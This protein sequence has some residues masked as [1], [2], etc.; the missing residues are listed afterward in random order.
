MKNTKRPSKMRGQSWKFQWMRVCRAR[1]EH[2][3]IARHRK[4]KREVVNPTRFQKQ[5]MHVSWKRMSPRDSDWNP[6][7]QKSNEDHIA[8]KGQNSMSHYS[9]V[10]R[11]TP[12]PQA[13][14]ILDAKAAVEKEWKN[15]K[16]RNRHDS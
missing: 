12:I 5:S 16:R 1:K 6:L 11:F 14:K 13:M 15:N 8:D 7:F 4:L 10:H 9:L 3:N 2:R